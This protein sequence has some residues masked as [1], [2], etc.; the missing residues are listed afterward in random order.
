M[1]AFL[2]TERLILRPLVEADADG[3]YPGWF[4]DEATCAGNSHHV[5]PYT[6]S[7]ALDYIRSLSGDRSCVVLA[8]ETKADKVHVGNVSLQ[9]IHP[10]HRSAELAII[11]GEP[12]ARGKGLGEEACRALISHG[13]KA[14]N[15]R[16]IQCGTLATNHGMVALALKLGF[17][18]EGV[19]TQAAFK[20]GAYVDVVEFGLLAS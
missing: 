9:Q 18:Q 6:E 15:L 19:R 11:M 2:E 3:S 10:V 4:N 1:N 13:F 17:V 7:Q 14:L 5:Y 16:R 8:M 12:S 20:S